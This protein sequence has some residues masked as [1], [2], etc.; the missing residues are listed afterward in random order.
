MDH[1]LPRDNPCWQFQPIPH[2]LICFSYTIKGPFQQMYFAVLLAEVTV[3]E[4][5]PAEL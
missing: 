4:P 3:V 2:W 1:A 5:T